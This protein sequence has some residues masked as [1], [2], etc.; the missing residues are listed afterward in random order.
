MSLEYLLEVL[1][2]PEDVQAD[3]YCE[4]N[5]KTETAKPAGTGKVVE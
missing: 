3:G 2:Q 5:F 4:V 1:R